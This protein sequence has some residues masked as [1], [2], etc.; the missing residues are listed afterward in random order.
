MVLKMQIAGKLK[1]KYL[2][3]LLQIHD[4]QGVTVAKWSPVTAKR[5]STIIITTTI[6][7]NITIVHSQLIANY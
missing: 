4:W 6:T 2:N 5:L 1:Y 7:I 3:E